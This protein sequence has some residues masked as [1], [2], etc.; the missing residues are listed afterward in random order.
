MWGADV[1]VDWG[2]T[3]KGQAKRVRKQ[4]TAAA[5]VNNFARQ[6][7]DDSMDNARYG[8]S[9]NYG[10]YRPTDSKGNQSRMLL[11][12]TDDPPVVPN[13]MLMMTR[14]CCCSIRYQPRSIFGFGIM[15]VCEMLTEVPCV[16][17]IFSL[18]A[19]APEFHPR[20]RIPEG[21][22]GRKGPAKSF[23]ELTESQLPPNTYFNF[24]FMGANEIKIK[25]N[26]SS[27]CMIAQALPIGPQ[28][29]FTF[30][31]I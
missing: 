4:R 26:E 16:W 19:A 18:N 28:S 27:Q 2:L 14:G 25:M 13:T 9:Q 21:G 23:P 20:A 1:Y 5:A 8:L 10:Y 12:Y 17:N 3:C 24:D 6:S 22:H 7:N 31:G 15:W 11:M 29:S 30:P